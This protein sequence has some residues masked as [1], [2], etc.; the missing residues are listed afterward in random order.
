[1]KR[2]LLLVPLICTTGE[3]FRESEFITFFQLAKQWAKSGNSSLMVIP[4]QAEIPTEYEIPGVYYLRVSKWFPY[5]WE[6][7]FVDSEVPDITHPLIGESQVDATVTSRSVS[8]VQLKRLLWVD[9]SLRVPVY[10]LESW[11]RPLALD[12]IGLDVTLRAAAY[13]E[14]TTFFPTKREQKHGFEIANKVMGTRGLRRAEKNARLR[15]HGI[16]AKYVQESAY[17]Y[18][19][20]PEPTL[21]FAAR[22]NPNKQWEQLLEIYQKVAILRPDVRIKAV[23]LGTVDKAKLRRLSKVEFLEPLPYDGY[24][25]LLCRSWMSASMS[26]E[27]G[28]SFG[29][30]EQVATG[31][32]VFFPDKAWAR[33]LVGDDWPYF[34]SSEAE[35]VAMILWALDH[36]KEARERV[37][38][39]SEAFVEEHDISKAAADIMS[40]V[41]ADV[42]KSHDVLGDFDR[43]YAQYLKEMPQR[44]TLRQFGKK[45]Q[46]KGLAMGG[47]VITYTRLSNWRNLYYWL[48][49]KAELVQAKEPT[50]E[51]K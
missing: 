34:Y 16:F 1:V 5:L 40:E 23:K 13:C 42:E 38:S 33:T 30:A 49:T 7:S 18:A 35:L 2:R 6:R 39:L 14:C 4:R 10:V 47:W 46:S 27:E 22:F 36:Y 43:Q 20:Y 44:F 37:Q 3:V 31:N 48:R 12:G 41:E 32:P 28:F 21:V 11:V 45:L 24:V 51:R 17:A 50:F 15:S 26:I 25:E 8:A 29:F 19:K 9:A